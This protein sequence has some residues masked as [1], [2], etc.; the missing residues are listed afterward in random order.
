MLDCQ[1]F[2]L[3]PGGHHLTNLMLHLANTLLLFLL[4]SRM[5]SAPYRSALVAA[6]FALHPLHV[7][8]VA[9]VAERKDVLSTLF[10]M[11]T[12]WTYL[13]Y[14]EH[15][16]LGRYLLTLVVF[17]LGLMAKPMLVTLPCVL[18]LLDYWP[19]DRLALRQAEDSIN[20]GAQ[21]G[22]RSSPQRSSPLRL[23]WEKVPFFVLAA[24]SSAVTLLVQQSS[25]AV[26]SVEAFPLSIRI[27]NGPLCCWRCCWSR[28][29]C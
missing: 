4:L 16:R 9:W 18:L 25:G 27:A 7:E 26:K 12:M 6:L 22:V 13:L 21:K 29:G 20:S 1:L 17:T 14:V 15:P 10:W 8:S 24:V 28:R 11:L 5:T 19:L 3:N 23:F 2:G